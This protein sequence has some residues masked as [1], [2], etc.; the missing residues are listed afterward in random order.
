MNAQETRPGGRFQ[1]AERGAFDRE[2]TAQLAE[3]ILA[4]APML[5]IVWPS[6]CQLGLVSF[7]K[8]RDELPD[9]R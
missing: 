1:A 6:L 7:S 9:L 5:E 2:E 3:S 8:W 4:T